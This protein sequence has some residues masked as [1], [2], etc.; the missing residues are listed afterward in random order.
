MKKRKMVRGK[1]GSKGKN[2]WEEKVKRLSRG[3]M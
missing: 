3:G 2:G 1:I